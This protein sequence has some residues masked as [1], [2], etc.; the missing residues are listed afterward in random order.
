MQ[1][2]GAIRVD[3]M[4][5]AAPV[6]ARIAIHKARGRPYCELADLCGVTKD[7]IISIAN[8]QQA[9]R[10]STHDKIMNVP[11]PPT[12][13]GTLR[14]VHAL[15]RMGFTK[16]YLAVETDQPYHALHAALH[17]RRFTAAM[18]VA[19]AD[20]FDRLDRGPSKITATKAARAGY[21]STMA[22]EGIDIDDPAARADI[23]APRADVPF[24][25]LVECAMNGDL[26]NR[27]GKRAKRAREEAIHR[28][29]G[30]SAEWVA[31]KIGCSSRTVL[32]VRAKH[33]SVSEVS[34]QEAA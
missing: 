12:V 7:T 11:L 15:M 32:R 8:G 3:H 6:A 34:S 5:D 20:A 22:W 4:R 24:S 23:G 17:R 26:A 25:I 27:G 2:L 28:F 9:L 1:I 29:A 21:P 14:R 16:R 31:A 30:K 19:I 18:M 33:V 13:I 10:T